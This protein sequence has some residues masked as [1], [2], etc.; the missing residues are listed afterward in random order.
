MTKV[1]NRFTTVEKQII[2]NCVK[3]YPTNLS[4]A[5]K[6][7]SKLMNRNIISISAHYYT[8]LR[9]NNNIITVGSE[10]GFSKNNIKNQHKDNDGNIKSDLQPIQYLIKEILNLSYKERD[11]LLLFFTNPN[12]LL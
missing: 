10:N 11:F 1:R 6:E 8:V 12:K 3:Q 5:F 2:L 7:A 9:K 4:F